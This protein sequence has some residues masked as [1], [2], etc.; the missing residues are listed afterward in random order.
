[1]N[2]RVA[3]AA[4]GLMAM[5]AV[6]AGCSTSQDAT[7]TESP[8]A[9]AS[10]T[11]SVDPS[12]GPIASVDPSLAAI[13]NNEEGGAPIPGAVDSVT[14]EGLS[15]ACAEAVAPVREVMAKY[16]SGLLVDSDA[17]NKILTDGINAAR[18]ACEQDASLTTEQAA[19]QWADFYAKEYF[20]W[21][22]G[23]TE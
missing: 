22:N 2:K 4:A 16:K 12:A 3:W 1:M 6:L 18:A 17:D 13:I 21:L 23:A 8:T 10:P 20:G 19:Q 14:Q 11:S 7:P 15:A 5:T 9:S